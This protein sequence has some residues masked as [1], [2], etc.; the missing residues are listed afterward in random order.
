M[1]MTHPSLSPQLGI[2]GNLLGLRGR[3]VRICVREVSLTLVSFTHLTL[4]WLRLPMGMGA[5]SSFPHK[6][7]FAQP[8]LLM[9]SLWVVC[10]G[11]VSI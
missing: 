7:S 8:V 2:W 11:N 1:V 5:W 4:V 3:V 6:I 9:G 10:D